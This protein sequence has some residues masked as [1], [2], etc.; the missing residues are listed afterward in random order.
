MPAAKNLVA[1]GDFNSTVFA[2]LILGVLPERC[3]R[4]LEIGCG[5]G[6]WVEH[7]ASHA[8]SVDAMDLDANAIT[9][10]QGHARRFRNV[11]WH[12]ADVQNLDRGDLR[13][14]YDAIV[15]IFSLHEVC[16][17]QVMRQI[18]GL[19]NPQGVLIVLDIHSNV[20]RSI[21][22]YI[23]EQLILADVLA[24]RSIHATA[25][26][27]GWTSLVIFL[28]SRAIALFAPAGRRHVLRD[29]AAGAPPALRDWQR[30]FAD[31]GFDGE[32][33]H[34][35]GT[36]FLFVGRQNSEHSKNGAAN[37]DR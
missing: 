22:S 18:A 32:L 30:A 3:R 33:S 25:R 2:P 24:W 1:F 5:Y 10:Q 37:H 15:S 29:L 11:S 20:R 4:L 6:H 19:L 21:G 31:A 27:I 16:L 36:T 7:F 23:F 13:Y 9:Y 12:V 17:P 34:I 35:L 8:D 26:S 14:G 28:I